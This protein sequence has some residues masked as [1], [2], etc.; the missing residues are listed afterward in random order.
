MARVEL[1]RGYTFEA[2]HFLPEV[3]ETHKCHRMHGHSFRVEL[4]FEGPVDAKMGWFID[5]GEVDDIFA[6]L[7]KQLDH[8]CLNEID[9]LEN[10]TSQHLAI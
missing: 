3:A 8:N 6:P 2:A 10:P 5:Y 9:G 1:V 7:H 4:Q